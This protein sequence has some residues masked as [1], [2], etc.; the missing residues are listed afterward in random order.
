MK[1]IK[2]MASRLELFFDQW[3]I[4]KME[5]LN[6]KLHNPQP[7]EVVIE[8]NKDWE[9]STCYYLTVFKDGEIFRMY[10][11][12]SDFD[13]KTESSP[14]ESFTC[15]AESVDGINWTKPE[16]NLYQFNGSKK[17]NII[18]QGVGTHNFTPFIDTNPSVKPE[19]RYKAVGS[20][21]LKNKPVLFAFVSKDGINWKQW[22][23]EPIITKGAFDS[24]NLA[25]YDNLRKKYFEYHRDFIIDEKDK[26][27]RAIM[28]S[29]S[30]DFENWTDPEFIDFEDSPL[31]HLYTN[32][33]MPYYR[34]PHIFIGFPKRFVEERKKGDHPYGGVSDVV[35]MVSRDGKLWK[36]YNEAFIRPGLQPERWI[37]RNNALA[38]GMIETS[39]KLNPNQKE[40]SLYSIEAYYIPGTRL[41]RFTIRLD[42]FVSVNAKGDTGYFVTHPIVFDGDRLIV[43]YST[44]AAGLVKI[45]V[46]DMEGKLI[47]PYTAEL[48]GDSTEQV[49]EWKT[50]QDLSKIKGK[51]VRLKFTMKDADLYSIR[52][53]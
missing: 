31:E 20:G 13:I 37:N 33:V 52:F 9:G 1:E 26:K 30:E 4:E 53:K 40:I 35:F 36:R 22:K 15:Y 14:H 19:E 24:Q 39:S 32:G 50:G 29:T 34:A 28:I 47:E 16:L 21:M 7:E 12:G 45:E 48:Y 46:M 51:P 6:F 38:W 41:R 8:F 44:S 5:K 23:E 17:N 43:N 10:Y 18:W 11:R 27:Y 25:F 42:G 49:V 3:L 2:N